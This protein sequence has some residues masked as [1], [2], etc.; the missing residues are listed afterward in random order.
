[1]IEKAWDWNNIN[2]NYWEI[3]DEYMYFLVNKWGSREKSKVLDLGCGIGRHSKL[4]AQ[5]NFDV[6]ALDISQSGLNR[7]NDMAREHNLN[8]KTV[9][10]NIVEVPLSEKQF[11]GIVAFNSVYHTD[12]NGF[13]KVISE[14]KRV[15]KNDGEAFI[16]LLSKDDPSFE[17]A[18]NKIVDENTRMKMEN[19]L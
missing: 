4:F 9:V 16:T 2:N 14:I 18:S 17:K 15:L 13:Y 6:T 12:T 3:P 10:G 8:M 5:N 11:D 7:V 19:Q 1:M